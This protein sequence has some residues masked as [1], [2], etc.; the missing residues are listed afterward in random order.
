MKPNLLSAPGLLLLLAATPA[1][2]V[3]DTWD[4]GGGNDLITLGDNWVDNTAPASDVANTDL[5]F[6]GLVRLTPA[7]NASFSTR[8][9][10]FNNTAGA[11]S[12]GGQTFVL[13]TTGIV[14]ND[15]QTM[16]FS[17]SVRFSGVASSTI[18]AAAGGLSFTG[19]VTLPS[20]SL[21]VAGSGPASFI[22]LNGSSA[23]NKKD[24]GT[25][26]WTPNLPPACDVTVDAG[27]LTMG[28]D[29]GADIFDPGASI[30]VNGTGTFNI[31]ESL[32]LNGSQLTRASGGIVNLATGKTL[33]VQNGGDA[34]ITG[35]FANSTA[36]TISV[37]GTGSTLATTGNLGIQG[38]SI[39]NIAAGGSIATGA[40]NVNVGTSG[41]NGAVTVDGA[42][43]SFT[44]DSLFIGQSG[45]TG[46]VTF[47][48]GSTGQFSTVGLDQ[49]SVAGT[50][51]S[52]AIQSGAT[53]TGTSLLLGSIVA[54][55]TGTT[56]VTGSGS[57]LTIAGAGTAI[58]GATSASSGTLNVNSSGTFNSGTGQ[59]T[60]SPTGTI[61]VVG[62]DFNANGNFLVNGGQVTVNSAGDFDVAPGTAFTVQA[63]GVANMGDFFA[64]NGS[65]FAVTGAGSTVSITVGPGGGLFS[66]NNGSTATFSNGARLQSLGGIG[67]A[68]GTGNGTL[69][70]DGAGTQLSAGSL[71]VTFGGV[72]SLTFSNGSTGTVGQLAVNESSSD[73]GAVG[74]VSI[75][76]GATVAVTGGGSAL[77][78]ARHPGIHTGTLTIDGPGSAL[79]MSGLGTATIGAASGGDGTLQVQNSGTF[80]SGTSLTTV[81]PTG[82][83]AITGGTYT[84]NGDL[85]LNGGQLTRGSS[86]VL[87]FGTARAFTVQNGGDA[88]FSDIG[89]VNVGSNNTVT[90]TGAGSTL[91]TMGTLSVNAGSSVMVSA[92]GAIS[93]LSA[94]IGSSGSNGTVTV[95]G[96][97]SSMSS[98][99]T[100]IGF[101]GV[102]GT[103]TFSNGS[104]GTFNTLNIDRSSTGGTVGAVNI[105]SGARVSIASLNLADFGGGGANSGTV[106]VT[107]AG[108][109][110]S[111]ISTATLGTSAGNRSTGTLTVESG[112]R[113]EDGFSVT[114]N[115][116][117]TL[118]VN[119]GATLTG[120]ANFSGT[121]EVNLAGHF[122]PGTASGVNQTTSVSF[123]QNMTFH[124]T[125]SITMEIGGT[126]PRT[127]HDQLVF[128]GMGSTQVKW[129]GTLKLVLIN[130]FAPQAGQTFNLFDFDAARDTGAFTT[131][132]V[133]TNGL[134]PPGLAFNFD[135]LY[136][137][138][139]IR[140]VSTGGITF[141]QWATTELGN[142]G[143]LPL[144]DHNGNGYLNL[145]EFALGLFPAVPATVEPGIALHL[146][147]DG[148]RLRLL[149]T[150]PLD[151]TG[152][153]LKIQASAD[154]LTWTDLATSENSAPFTGPGFISENRA[155]PLD[156][157]G[158]VEARDTV[159]TNTG[160]R[161]QVRLLI[162]LAP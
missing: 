48:N 54:A 106:T 13:G 116:L 143:A 132:D 153:T 125:T 97:G 12:I 108:S 81:H 66:V 80:T 63:G 131:I 93:P 8:S 114:L 42:G 50:N 16:T 144:D 3:T 37:S 11:F 35:A 94:S 85:T 154:L 18:N 17:N 137:T 39:L 145:I 51:G 27:T 1:L 141:S 149:F 87:N 67:I 49:S 14:N 126:A 5:I 138:G 83:I 120:R 32:T 111:I 104:T 112:A 61:S 121:G 135:E 95:D 69:T 161:R 40:G 26:T 52:L 59:T 142:P 47:S 146:Y 103:L 56:T 157:P 162:T 71:T 58:I 22:N 151:R 155:H 76:S 33:T 88:I 89:G 19:A 117:G 105:Q 72:G 140:V 147:P 124:P 99:L 148:E 102:T 118:N 31:N 100:S 115:A 79:T 15:T 44:G 43:S 82:T 28:A 92:G 113:F 2:A 57:T 122:L 119:S 75:E 84:S 150:R 29:G 30:A 62:G 21:I 36:S 53:V 46:S 74:T 130:G 156:Q 160:T 98:T 20:D 55:N 77:R 4:G 107:G 152:L 101:N 110:L 133:V 159:T 128:N 139:V 109:V 86:G 7:L 23:V 96:S 41:G 9:I 70:I 123:A 38:G 90:V 78:I 136:T 64:T 6:A 158:L 127:Q 134:M 10:T 65:T 45:R 25:M 91:S 68:N 24:A 73:S 34:T 129:D 60:V